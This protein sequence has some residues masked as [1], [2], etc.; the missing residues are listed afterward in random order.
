M[1]SMKRT[2]TSASFRSSLS[3]LSHEEI[4]KRIKNGEENAEENA[5]LDLPPEVWGVVVGYLNTPTLG[6]L[7]L[8]TS[9]RMKTI[10]TATVTA[11]ESTASSTSTDDDDAVWKVILYH[12]WGIEPSL[13]LLE[14]TTW[15]A[16]AC[17]RLLG[18]NHFFDSPS[19]NGRDPD[20]DPTDTY[21]GTFPRPL[22]YV[23]D[24]YV[25]VITAKGSHSKDSNHQEF[26]I[27]KAIRGSEIL[28]FFAKGKA[29]VAF[30]EPLWTM[31]NK[32]YQL[33]SEAFYCGTGMRIRYT[34]CVTIIRLPDKK[35]VRSAKWYGTDIVGDL[36]DYL[37]NPHFYWDDP[38]SS[39]IAGPYM[40]RNYGKY[41]MRHFHLRD[42]CQIMIEASL[43]HMPISAND[44]AE[45]SI[46]IFGFNL[47]ASFE[48]YHLDGQN[49]HDLFE[50]EPHRFQNITFAHFLDAVELRDWEQK[51]SEVKTEVRNKRGRVCRPEFI[52]EEYGGEID[53]ECDYDPEES[54]TSES[55]DHSDSDG[56]DSSSDE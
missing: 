2:S 8:Q 36:K 24:D 50:R 19:P 16:E 28:D 6:R 55:G 12:M 51:L 18:Y 11:S 14:R 23:P 47:E 27:C 42:Y 22:R 31:I 7:V 46:G 44:G 40:S 45:D 49:V 20:P 52:S 10:I 26:N 32:P 33:W 29:T 9:K 37:G 41:L 43:H 25:F 3:F 30:Q 17:V 21:N 1:P 35:T 5:F 13:E 48:N 38:D 39:Y 34:T 53:D 56:D 54:S 4:S 15:T